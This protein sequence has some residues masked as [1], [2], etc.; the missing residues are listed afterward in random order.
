MPA[1]LNM[2][3]KPTISVPEAD[4]IPIDVANYVSAIGNIVVT[5]KSILNNYAR[6][7][8]ATI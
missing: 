2:V 7:N 5:P 4:G 1:V 8:T 6:K 3:D